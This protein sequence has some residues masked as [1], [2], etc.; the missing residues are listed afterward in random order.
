MLI[1]GN[2][3]VSDELIRNCFCCDLAACQGECC[4]EGDAGA[5]IAPDEIADLEDN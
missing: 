1:V 4:I 3:I 2:V 5:P